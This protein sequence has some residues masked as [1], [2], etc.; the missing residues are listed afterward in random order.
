M[1]VESPKWTEDISIAGLYYDGIVDRGKLNEVL[2]P[3]KRDTVSTFRTHSSLRVSQPK[4]S[5][6]SMM[7]ISHKMSK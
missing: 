1:S 5:K 2:E 6:W 7:K 4:K 3:H